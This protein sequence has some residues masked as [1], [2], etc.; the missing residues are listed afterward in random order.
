MG[1]LFIHGSVSCTYPMEYLHCTMVFGLKKKGNRQNLSFRTH[2][3]VEVQL[4]QTKILEMHFHFLKLNDVASKIAKYLFDDKVGNEFL[5]DI[6]SIR[7]SSDKNAIL[8]VISQHNI[9]LLFTPTF[10]V[11]S[12]LPSCFFCRRLD[13]Y[14]KPN[15]HSKTW[16]ILHHRE[17]KKF[18]CFFLSIKN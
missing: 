10:I 1:G 14:M 18:V 2:F 16:R 17:E 5:E 3:T 13:K 7:G 15:I 8:N 11:V 9:W 6:C 4:L 12:P